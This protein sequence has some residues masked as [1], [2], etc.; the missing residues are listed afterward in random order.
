MNCTC[1]LKMW[2]CVC[3]L[4]RWN[5]VYQLEMLNCVDTC[6]LNIKKK[7]CVY[8]SWKCENACVCQLKMW[9]FVCQL[10]MCNCVYQLKMWNCVYVSRKYV[11]MSVKYMGQWYVLVEICVS[12]YLRWQYSILTVSSLTTFCPVRSLSWCFSN[13]A[14]HLIYSWSRI[15]LHSQ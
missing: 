5:C 3:H 1:Q 8:F 9:N 12:C 13:L 15:T 14:W 10:K 6:K 11:I 4:K 7:N 2:N